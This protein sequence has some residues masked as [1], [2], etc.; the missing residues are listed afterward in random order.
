MRGPGSGM[1]FHVACFGDFMATELERIAA[2]ANAKVEA[3]AGSAA[4]EG[5]KGGGEPTAAPEDPA[6]DAAAAPAVAPRTKRSN[7]MAEV[8][9]V[10]EGSG[11]APEKRARRS[12]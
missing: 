12:T 3:M 9:D 8:S 4:E 11:E 2:A 1:I 6:E 10:N 7:P 5:R